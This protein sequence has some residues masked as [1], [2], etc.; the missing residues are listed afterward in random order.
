MMLVV[1]LL[2]AGSTLLAAARSPAAAAPSSA[3]ELQQRLE[4]LNRQADQQVEDYLQAKL[5]VE[6]TRNPSESLNAES[7]LAAPASVFWQISGK[8]RSERREM[9]VVPGGADGI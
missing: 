8:W 5:A 4:G 2:V 1:G 6:R 3:R 9:I 7:V